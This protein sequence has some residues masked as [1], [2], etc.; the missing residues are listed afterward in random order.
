MS[1]FKFT[2]A[3]DLAIVSVSGI[4]GIV[5]Q[6]VDEVSATRFALKFG[7]YLKGGTVAIAADTRKTSFTLKSAMTSGLIQ[8][9]CTVFD[10]GYSS[11]PSVFKEVAVRGLDGGVIVTA[12]HNP[13]AWNG[14]KFVI[15]PGRGIFEPEL[16][17]IQSSPI[18]TSQNLGKSFPNRSFIS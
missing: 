13:P 14:I 7:N 5:N 2:G 9:G 3:F 4:R 18:T 6:D 1:T 17:S 16:E 8:T 15:R 11:T 10:L 12:S